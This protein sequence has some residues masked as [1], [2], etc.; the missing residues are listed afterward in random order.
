MHRLKKNE[1]F[2]HKNFLDRR[3]KIKPKF[4]FRELVK[5]ADKKT[6]FS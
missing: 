4:K 2:A 5:T 3:K 6:V 1:A